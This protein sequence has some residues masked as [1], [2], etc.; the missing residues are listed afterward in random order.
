MFKIQKL[1]FLIS[2]YIGCIAVSELMGAKTF[3][4]VALG[5]F[6]LS[7]SVAIFAIP[8]IYSINDIITEVHG[9]ERAQSVV[10]SGRI[11]FWFDSPLLVFKMLYIRY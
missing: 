4:L 3:P 8:L 10:R 1:D 7:A 9:K 6:K 5:N 2:F 11:S